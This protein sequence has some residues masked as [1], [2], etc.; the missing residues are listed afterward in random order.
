M[1]S[2]SLVNSAAAPV[3]QQ[4]TG[5]WDDLCKLLTSHKVSALKDGPGWMPAYIEPGPRTGVRAGAWCVLVLDIEAKTQNLPDKTK[6]VI[7]PLPPNLSA[8]ALH[9]DVL[10]WAACLA[11]SHSH[12]APADTGTLGARYR[13]VIRLSRPL[14]PQEIKPVGLHVAKMLYVLDC[15]DTGCLESARL[16]Y[17]PRCPADRKALAETEI[18]K[19]KPLDVDDILCQCIGEPEGK[20]TGKL[21]K[22]GDVPKGGSDLASELV[23]PQTVRDLRS[24]LNSLRAD[25][26]KLWVDVGHALK[27]LGEQGRSLWLDWSQT[28]EKYDPEVAARQWESFRPERTSYRFVF[29]RAQESGW[30][31]PKSKLAVRTSWVPPDFDA[32]TG[33]ILG[34]KRSS[35]FQF[36]SASELVTTPHLVTY[37]VDE[38][39][40]HP[41]LVLLFA[42]PASGKSL[43]AI[44]WAA[45]VAT[46]V[47]WFGHDTKQGSVFY[48]AGEGHAGISRRLRAWELHTHQSLENAPLYVSQTPAALMDETS[49][50]EV[51]EAVER[52][53]AEHGSP[54]LIVIDT[55]ARNMGNGD[56]NSNADV[57]LFVHHIDLMRHRLG[58]TVILVHHSGHG[59]KDRARGGSSLPA[60][61]DA[62]FRIDAKLGGL[63]LVHIK[64]K[65]SEL[66]AP[67]ML[68]LKQQELPGWLDSKGREMTSAVLVKREGSGSETQQRKQLTPR[69]KEAI[70]AF[71]RAADEHGEVGEGGLFVSVHVDAWRAEYYRTSTDDTPEAKKKSFQRV[72]QDLRNANLLTV[73]NDLYQLDWFASGLFPHELSPGHRKPDTGQPGQSRD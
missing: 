48:L 51:T 64:S 33:E 10:E 19:G 22:A 73:E 15:L 57:G 3:Q 6:C 4:I 18:V 32:D 13:V 40:E 36:V 69:M 12:E 45:C 55:F 26:R 59:E 47:P 62:S 56:E 39:I 1:L 58:C 30:V 21:Q 43:L 70:N 14:Q 46:G 60:A 49:L 44:D 65:E 28:S 71:Q 8:L 37:L 41:A 9:L 5:T 54:A 16:F 31:N 11:T 7:G 25:D 17:L 29:A 63:Q 50:K 53:S 27:T 68:E 24:A 66:S 2:W 34:L 67:L 42:P 61:M 72:R 23:S 20:S 38:L 35:G 52:L